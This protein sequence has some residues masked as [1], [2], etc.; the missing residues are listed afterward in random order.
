LEL[1]LFEQDKSGVNRFGVDNLMWSKDSFVVKEL[2][3]FEEYLRDKYKP[4]NSFLNNVSQKI[5]FSGGKRLR[6]ALVIISGMMGEYDRNKIFPLAAAIETLHTATLVHDDIIDN[7]KTRRGQITTSEKH[8]IN[9]AIYTGDYLLANSIL[10]LAESGLAVKELDRLAKAVKM[11]CT[12]EVSQYLNRY[13]LTS[14]SGYLKRIMKKTG[15]LFSASCAIGSFASNCDYKQV[16]T[17]ARIGMNIGIAFQIRDDLLD[18]EIYGKGAEKI[19][20]PITNDIKNGIITLPFIYSAKRSETVRRSIEELFQITDDLSNVKQREEVFTDKN[21]NNNKDINSYIRQIIN[22]VIESGG[23]SD[24]KALKNRYIQKAR[25]LLE[26]LPQI[27][28]EAKQAL[29]DIINW[30]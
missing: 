11:I 7:A 29:E 2:N 30:L 22:D 23:V 24:A 6:P 14:V 12:G 9:I 3:A 28:N 18:I 27:T 15:I 21:V 17:M 8:G 16:R 1:R 26:T 5:I 4:G 13:K 10:L 25:N 19:G 20:K